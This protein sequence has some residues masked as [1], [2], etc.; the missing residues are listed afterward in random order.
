M[1]TSEFVEKYQ[2][3][4]QKDPKSKVFAPL[5][6]AYRKMGM[7]KEALQICER[8]VNLHP[9]FSSGRVAYA[10]VLMDQNNFETAVTHLEKA[11]ELS[12]ENLLAHS[13]LAEC[14]L[15]V[16]DVK[17]AL[18]AYKMALFI[19]PFD[20]RSAQMIKKLESLTADEYDNDL[21]EMKPLLGILS[22]HDFLSE[23]LSEEKPSTAKEPGFIQQRQLERILSLTDA[24]I[25]RNDAEN[26]LRTLQKA[27]ELVGAHPEIERRQKLLSNRDEPRAAPTQNMTQNTQ[28]RALDHL[29]ILLQRI[30]ERRDWDSETNSTN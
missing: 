20:T 11:V 15:K 4:Y 1:S 30:N 8:G 18:R 12:P 5:A 19:N 23:K 25:A 3:L 14:Y 7:L 22:K 17:K 10:K 27:E 2:E 24:F 13:L 26:A 6:E 21:F 16:R 28:K 9:H 29:E